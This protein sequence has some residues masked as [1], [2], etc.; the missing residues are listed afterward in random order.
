MLRSKLSFPFTLITLGL[1]SCFEAGANGCTQ[2][3][4]G[5]HSALLASAR[6]QRREKEGKISRK[7]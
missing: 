6:V 5:T 3:K 4:L 2:T 7:I 1:D